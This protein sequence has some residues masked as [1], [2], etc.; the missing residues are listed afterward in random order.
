MAYSPA[1]ESARADSRVSWR[2]WAC[3]L[4]LTKAKL[5]SDLDLSSSKV[6]FAPDSCCLNRKTIYQ[7]SLAALSA[8][9]GWQDQQAFELLQPTEQLTAASTSIFL[10]STV[11]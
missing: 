11:S 9:L 2:V 1:M 5:K 4:G 10:C 3:L 7:T 6:D 8:I